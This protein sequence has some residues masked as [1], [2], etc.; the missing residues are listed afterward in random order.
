MNFLRYP[1]FYLSS[2]AQSA[3]SWGG[4][5]LCSL[6]DS[7]GRNSV[8]DYRR[9][10]I[11]QMGHLGDVL[12][13]IPLINAFTDRYPDAEITVVVG[14]WGQKVIETFAP[15]AKVLRY[16]S[17]KFD[18]DGTEGRISSP[19]LRDFDLLLHVRSD[20]KLVL[21]YFRNR[22]A[23]FLNAL[24]LQNDLRWAPLY[25]LGLPWPKGNVRHQYE[26]FRDV[27]ENRGIPVP[28][29][30]SLEVRPEW[31]DS[32]RGLL[33]AKGIRMGSLAVIHPGAPWKPRRWPLDNFVRIAEELVTR[34]KL[35]VA[36]I[37]SAD[38]RSLV[39][40]FDAQGVPV[41]DLT[42]SLELSQLAAILKAARVYIGNDSGPAHLAAMVG[43]PVLCL[44]GPQEPGLFG[45]L[46]RKRVW[47]KGNTFCSPCWQ[48]TCPYG[49]RNCMSL[50]TVDDAKVAVR[51]L[52]E[53]RPARFSS[54][55]KE[56]TA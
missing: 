54:P 28:E 20:M 24:P 9:I 17:Q 19:S 46:A 40:A 6:R 5:A 30:P 39:G 48:R 4:M 27:L 41:L 53:G 2:A 8:G 15:R 1:F 56:A 42:G 52:L 12:L 35:D 49:E 13:T 34:Y 31:D 18:R 32:L 51:R 55:V 44:Y 22:K 47:L 7:L 10:A 16:D 38:E 3:V 43:A 26:V 14:G 50:I 25:L 11:I 45:A 29:R 33:G 37:G 23:V 36:V 21:E